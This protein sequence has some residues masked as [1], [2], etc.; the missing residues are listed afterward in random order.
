MFKFENGSVILKQ[1]GAVGLKVLRQ[2][3]SAAF[4]A[5]V[6]AVVAIIGAIIG[7]IVG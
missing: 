3:L 6:P 7:A 4:I 1:L 2:C 5:V